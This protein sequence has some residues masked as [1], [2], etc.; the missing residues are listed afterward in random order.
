MEREYWNVTPAHVIPRDVLLK[1]AGDYKLAREGNRSLLPSISELYET[2]KFSKISSL[3]R[4]NMPIF[5]QT[6]EMQAG[7]IKG[8]GNGLIKVPIVNQFEEE[9]ADV[10]L[11]PSTRAKADQVMVAAV[12]IVN[13]G[14]ASVNSDITLAGA[15][16]D[17]RHK[18]LKNSF[19]GAYA[20]RLGG[21]P[22]HVI[23][24]PTH[25][26][27]VLDDPN[28]TL[29]LSLVSRDTDFEEQSTLA[30]ISVR[31]VYAKAKGPDKVTETRN[32]L[33]AKLE[34]TVKA[35]QFASSSEVVLAT[36]RLYPKVNLDNYALPRARNVVQTYGQYSDSGITFRRPK[37]TN[38]GIVLNATGPITYAS[39]DPENSS[40][41]PIQHFEER[42]GSLSDE[43][44]EDYKEG[45]ALMEE[46]TLEACTNMFPLE[47]IPE[48][49][50]LLFS[51]SASIP[52]NVTAGT[53]ITGM[54]LNDLATHNGVHNQLLSMLGKIPGSL[55]CRVY[56]EV[57]PTSGIGLAISYVEG[58]ESV[59]LG[60]NLGRLLGIQHKKWNPAI[61]PTIDF[62][63]K[64]FSCCDWWSM[65]YL[66]SAKYAPVITILC[67]DKWLNAPKTE[68]R[69]SFALYFEP[70]VILPKQIATLYDIPGFMLRKELGNLRFPQGARKAYQFE[71]NFGKPQVDGK[72]V[73]MNLASA[74]C[75]LSQYMKA[76]VILDLLLMS[77][78]MMGATL[79][80]ALVCGGKIK[81]LGNL[82][83]LDSLP[84]VTF[85][86]C[87]GGSS[88]RSLRFKKD[89][90]PTLMTLDRWEL[91]GEKTD[92]VGFYF[93]IYQRDSVSSALEGDMVLRVS[94]RSAGEVQLY[95]V[96]SGYPTMAT[97]SLKGKTGVRD[98]GM[99]IRKPIGYKQAQAHT[100]GNEFGH[101]FYP[102]AFW[103]Y[104]EG[105][106]DGSRGE[107]DISTHYLKMRLDGPKN[108][109]GFKILHSPFTR[110]LQNCAWFKGTLEWKVVIL[111]NS[112]MMSYRRTSQA[113]I[114]A[115][116]SSL[117]SYEFFSGVLSESS[118][119][120]SFSRNVVGTVDGFRSMGW[121][122]Q[123]EK[124]FYKLCIALGNIHEYSAVYVY[125]KFHPDVEIAGQQ[126]AGHYILEKDAVMFKEIAY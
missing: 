26:V 25:R 118:G 107:S 115:H 85:T 69:I 17:K 91:D 27:P 14:F 74:Y 47:G 73:T 95:G 103:K 101:V 18:T 113:I 51:G 49:M 72:S 36:P 121:D 2:S 40:K 62:L 52:Q 109:E 10:R 92:E 29:E 9:R 41:E 28:E 13:D 35:Q 32:L 94:A 70:D 39:I 31:T 61:E 71:V 65:H 12:E 82:Q 23:F 45:Q 90:F 67:L 119:T 30:N 58:N 120:V 6:S 76:D 93:V 125:G 44:T 15:L 123:G 20:S 104:E 59:N 53:K 60:N 86:F 66:G 98:F 34:D 55:K 11:N 87:K 42:L 8:D 102:V 3:L 64:P 122:V 111:A 75:G 84:H 124:K 116:E 89:L 57:A 106:Y 112:E 56:C 78:P 114:T 21:A 54:Y 33:A 43:D 68:S 46:E 4:R 50:R 117:S 105:K 63:V 79:T 5:M 19:K 97:R 7:V 77:S 22:S 99:K 80:V 16:Y 37:F 81:H 126:K 48:T 96:S 88:T 110:L 24:Y 38:T 108:N 1:K 83:T 100:L